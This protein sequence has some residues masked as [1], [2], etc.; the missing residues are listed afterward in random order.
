MDASYKYKASVRFNVR[1]ASAADQEKI[2]GFVQS[3][4][5][6]QLESEFEADNVNVAIVSDEDRSERYDR[7]IYDGARF[8]AE[9][10]KDAPGLMKRS[11]I[12]AGGDRSKINAVIIAMGS[13][14]YEETFYRGAMLD[15][16]VVEAIRDVLRPLAGFCHE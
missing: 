7:L 3:V 16:A 12:G 15:E 4:L 6:D 10:F 14:D 9:M 1:L 5:D 8:F 13:P 11:L 2:R